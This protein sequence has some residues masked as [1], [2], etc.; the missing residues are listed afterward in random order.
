MM[1]TY[2]FQGYRGSAKH[3][4]DCPS[5]MKTG[6]V[7]AFH[8]EHTVNPFNRGDDGRPKQAAE[9]QREAKAAAVA[10]RDAFAREPL[11]AKCEDALSYSER[12]SL[13]L[14]R[15]S[16]SSPEGGR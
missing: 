11:C 10:Q 3:R 13:R 4:F 15:N 12:S 8:A 5:C 2:T 7:R 16:P 1:A 9:V 6:R 14:R